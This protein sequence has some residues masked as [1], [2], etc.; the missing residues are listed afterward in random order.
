[1]LLWRDEKNEQEVSPSNCVQLSLEKFKDS[2][3][4]TTKRL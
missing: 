3:L 1:M 2:M 4:S